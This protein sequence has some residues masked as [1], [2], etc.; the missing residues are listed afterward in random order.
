MSLPQIVFQEPAEDF[1][2]VDLQT[3]CDP[4]EKPGVAAFRQFVIDHQGGGDLGIVRACG[5]GGVSEHKEGRAWDW[6]I[7]AADPAQSAKANELIQW[8]LA[9]NADMFRRVGLMYIIWNQN[10]WSTK[11][12]TW[13]PYTGAD[14]HTSHVHFSFGWQG[15]KADTSFFR[16]LRGDPPKTPVPSKPVVTGPL[17]TQSSSTDP[18]FWFVGGAV[19]GLVLIFCIK[20]YAA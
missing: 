3:T 8:L 4:S 20:K 5:I 2:P 16:W 17:S 6:Q 19:V 9:N 14:P 11:T 1:A 13:R 18:S 12:N 10:I 15:A 7:S